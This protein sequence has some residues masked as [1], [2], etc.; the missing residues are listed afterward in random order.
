MYVD[1]QNGANTAANS[2]Y[3]VCLNAAKADVA[4]KLGTAGVGSSTIPIYLS[5][6]SPVACGNTLGV[7]ITGKAAAATKDGNGNVIS[8]T[9]LPLSG[10][11][12]TGAIITPGND[13]VVIRPA[14]NN[15]DQIGSS[16]YKFWQIYATTFYGTL[17]GNASTATKLQTARTISLTGDVTGS[18]TFD[19]SGNL[20]IATSTNHN[21]DST[22]VNVTGD[23][24]TGNFYISNANLYIIKNG[25][26]VCHNIDTSPNSLWLNWKDNDNFTQLALLNESYGAA[27]LAHLC[28][29]ANGGAVEDYNILHSGNYTSYAA[30]VSHSHTISQVTWLAAENLICTG[31]NSEWS[32]DMNDN[33]PN[34]YFHIWSGYL[35]NSCM[36]FENKTGL[37]RAPYGVYGGLWND[38]AEY[39]NQEEEIEPGYIVISSKNGKVRKTIQRLSPFDGVVSDTFGFAIGDTDECKTPLAVAGRV[40][41]YC[42]GDR[43]L[44]E[45][46]DV[47]CASENGKACKMTR[48]EICAYPDRI[49]GTVSEIPDYEEWGQNP[50]KVNG[51]I[52]IKV[53]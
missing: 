46:G 43:N 20:S 29:R 28:R 10:G 22:Y 44:Y 2:Q 4:T 12:M 52:W 17:S 45:I 16:S 1:I 13:S 26:T 40:L 53:R 33:A 42:E 18:G 6:G 47:V 9:Y 25:R 27:H 14:K 50:V 3:R 11:T 19:G 32:I 15:Y 41:V 39:R 34:S 5:A 23:T 51:R 37:C 38:Y 48:E 31:D 7:N 21:H 24:M 36:K 49:V 35:G 30:P 8:S